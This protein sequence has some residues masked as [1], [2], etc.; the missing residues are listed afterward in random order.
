MLPTPGSL[1]L[2]TVRNLKPCCVVGNR[3]CEHLEAQA[4]LWLQAK[5]QLKSLPYGE[6]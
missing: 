5:E 4:A 2:T 6:P 3:L 1:A